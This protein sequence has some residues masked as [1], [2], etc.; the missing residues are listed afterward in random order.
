[1][2]ARISGQDGSSS[3][4][5]SGSVGVPA[6]TYH[7]TG[8]PSGKQLIFTVKAIDEAGNVSAASEVL[9]V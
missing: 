5:S 3:N 6:T 1:M 7:L 9:S 4:S 8:L 2:I